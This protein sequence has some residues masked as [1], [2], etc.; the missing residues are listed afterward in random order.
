MIYTK[1]VSG[2][3]EKQIINKIRKEVFIDELNSSEEIEDFYD[4]FSFSAIVFEGD[5][6]VGTARLTF[7]EGKNM[8]D[9]LCVLKEYRGKRY[10]DLIIRL[11]VRRS[12]DMGSAETFSRV[13]E[14]YVKLFESIGFKRIDTA[15][16]SSLMM[17][18]GDV[19]GHCC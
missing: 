9:K 4:E 12:Y 8:I 6:P 13:D 3:G 17:M 16:G 18:E 10:G 19:G 7:K 14:K 2:T 11:L 1:I 5:K 15:G